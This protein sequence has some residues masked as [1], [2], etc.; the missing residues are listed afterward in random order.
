MALPQVSIH[1][2]PPRGGSEDRSEGSQPGTPVRG[3]DRA[4]LL[5]PLLE[6]APL[7]L[8][9]KP[10]VG[11]GSGAFSPQPGSPMGRQGEEGMSPRSLLGNA[12]RNSF[13]RSP[14]E[15]ST[16]TPLGFLGGT[17]LNPTPMVPS[18]HSSFRSRRMSSFAGDRSGAGASSSPGPSHGRSPAHAAGPEAHTPGAS[19]AGSGHGGVGPAPAPHPAPAWAQSSSARSFHTPASSDGGAPNAATTG[20]GQELQPHRS[21]PVAWAAPSPGASLG[22]TASSG[23]GAA[24]AAAAAAAE[25]RSTWTPMGLST[26]AHVGRS[27]SRR[28]MSLALGSQAAAAAAATSASLGSGGGGGGAPG[29]GVG[30]GLMV[31]GVGGGGV[32]LGTMG[33]GAGAG[34]SSSFR[35]RRFVSSTGAVG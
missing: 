15:A 7:R 23:P 24:S 17:G 31:G 26:G 6:L 4:E 12:G 25:A 28:R 18:P 8:Q 16:S 35:Q 10:S 29:P 21:T 3:A 1:Q 9:R 27:P 34:G 20:G 22:R 13:G 11:G 19:P 5:P 32:G 33:V 14:L 30:W 2:L